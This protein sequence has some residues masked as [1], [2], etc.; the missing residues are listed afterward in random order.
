MNFTPRTTRVPSAGDQV[1]KTQTHGKRFI[2][3]S[4]S[5]YVDLHVT[6]SGKKTGSLPV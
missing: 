5:V 1:F 6:D 2:F 4:S 3:K